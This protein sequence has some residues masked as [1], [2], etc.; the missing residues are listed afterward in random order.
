MTA[1]VQGPGLLIAFAGLLGAA[2]VSLAAAAAHV[3][4]STPLRAAAEIAMVHAAATV[5]FVGLSN[6]TIRPGLWRSIAAALVLGACLFT[7]TVSL[8]VLADFRPLPILAP[9]GGTLTILAWIAA[10]LAGFHEAFST[11][12]K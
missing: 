11:G 12:K 4:D 8:G 6:H 7:A 1:Q 9:V 2:G 5:S 10:A 3:S